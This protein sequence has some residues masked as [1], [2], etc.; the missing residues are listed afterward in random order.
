MSFLGICYVDCGSGKAANTMVT[1]DS[2]NKCIS[3]T[4]NSLNCSAC[5]FDVIHSP[6]PIVCDKCINNFAQNLMKDDTP[7]EICADTFYLV[8]ALGSV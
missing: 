7:C 4:E 5:H 1:E 6:F 3:C 8:G 2:F